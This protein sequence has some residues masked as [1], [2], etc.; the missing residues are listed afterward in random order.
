MFMIFRKTQKQLKLPIV[1]ING[2]QIECVDNCN[3]LGVIIDKNLTLKNHLYEISNK[4]FRIIG[5]N[6]KLK[7]TLP[8][9]IL[10]KIYNSKII[11][12]IHSFMGQGKQSNF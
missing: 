3:F 11:P 4:I 10:N 1:E 12:H 9:N 6:N 5:I 7:F 8:Q 2:I